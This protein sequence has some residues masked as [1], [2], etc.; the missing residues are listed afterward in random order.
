MLVSVCLL[1]EPIHTGTP[2]WLTSSSSSL[3]YGRFPCMHVSVDDCSPSCTISGIISSQAFIPLIPPHTL[4]LGPSPSISS[5]P[6]E[7]TTKLVHLHPLALISLF[8]V[9]KTSQAAS[10]QSFNNTS[11]AQWDSWLCCGFPISMWLTAHLFH[12]TCLHGHI[13]LENAELLCRR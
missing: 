1:T 4:L 12:H 6:S 10:A 3:F 9:S 2:K 5:P 13:R 7:Y 11:D 8:H